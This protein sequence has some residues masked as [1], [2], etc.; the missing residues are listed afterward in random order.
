M[1]NEFL[2]AK[3]K[4]GKSDAKNCITVYFGNLYDAYHILPHGHG[5]LYAH[6]MHDGFFEYRISHGLFENGKFI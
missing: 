1:L 2:P 6:T 3:V 4:S 5:L